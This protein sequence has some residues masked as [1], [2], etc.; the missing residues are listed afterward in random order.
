MISTTA[1]F[2]LILYGMGMFW[3]G[4]FFDRSVQSPKHAAK[5]PETVMV[6][7]GRAS[8]RNPG[9]TRKTDYSEY[10]SS[11]GLYAPVKPGKGSRADEIKIDS[12]ERP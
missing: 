4:V 7:R 5:E 10:K 6:K 1:V 2:A 3:L 8:F 11:N 12:R 9:Q